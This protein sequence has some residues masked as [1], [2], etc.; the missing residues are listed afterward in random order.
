MI[1]RDR[2]G[3]PLVIPPGG[4][5]PVAYTRASSLGKVLDDPYFL[6]LWKQRMVATGLSLR[7][8]LRLA[9]HAHIGDKRTLN[10]L[11]KQA[12]EAAQASAGATIGTALHRL[13]ERMD[14]GEQVSADGFD[15]DLEAYRK[16]TEGMKHL[17]IEAFMVCDELKVAGTP[18]RITLIDDTATVPVIADVKTQRTLDFGQLV[19]AVQL[20]CYAH[21]AAYTEGWREA[22]TLDQERALVIHLPAGQ[23]KATLHWIDV[24]AGWEAAKCAVQVRDWRKRKDLLSPYEVPV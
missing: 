16:A 5:G 13:V 21:S 7:P 4:G 8:E 2:W 23:G 9:V 6:D 24:A 20:A 17:S 18:D 14:S 10:H 3:K 12:M 19:I 1:E 22:T 11:C 15:A